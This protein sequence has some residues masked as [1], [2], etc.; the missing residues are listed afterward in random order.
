MPPR[1]HVRQ[2]KLLAFLSSLSWHTHS[3]CFW[4]SYVR[5]HPLDSGTGYYKGLTFFCTCSTIKNSG[6]MDRCN[7][8]PS[9]VKRHHIH[10][11]HG[12]PDATPTS[13]ALSALHPLQQPPSPL[14]ALQEQGR[15]LLRQVAPGCCFKGQR[16]LWH[17]RLLPAWALAMTRSC[18]AQVL[19]H[20]MR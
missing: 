18:V 12:R 6:G 10:F 2:S 15:Q 3:C 7:G 13:N 5:Y 20:A 1:E 16:L 19:M 4:P 17:W 11:T 14:G 9:V 8:Q